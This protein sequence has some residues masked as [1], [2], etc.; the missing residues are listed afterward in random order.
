MGKGKK[1]KRPRPMTVVEA[2]EQLARAVR[3]EQGEATAPWV[4]LA[5][6]DT[7]DVA[8]ADQWAAFINRPGRFY[9]ATIDIPLDGQ[10]LGEKLSTTTTF[11]AD[12]QQLPYLVE[13][14]RQVRGAFGLHASISLA[15]AEPNVE[16]R[17]MAGPPARKPSTEEHRAAHREVV[18][19]H[20]A[21]R[22]LPSVNG[23]GRAHREARDRVMAAAQVAQRRGTSHPPAEAARPDLILRE[24]CCGTP[25]TAPHE[26]G[27]SYEPRPDNPIDYTGPAEVA[28]WRPGL[29]GEDGSPWE[30]VSD[31]EFTRD[32]LAAMLPGQTRAEVAAE[33][34][35]DPEQIG[36]TVH[37]AD[38][39]P[40]DLAAEL[41]VPVESLRRIPMRG[42]GYAYTVTPPAEEPRGRHA[43]PDE[44]GPR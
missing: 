31:R 43:A 3:R 8:H 17:R 40:E 16:E 32:E 19:Q 36:G 6:L 41:G 9:V 37:N 1:N 38:M 33:L 2:Q 12:D 23:I 4:D 35:Q 44:A 14:L 21:E 11:K 34:G 10:A 39:L 7:P 28:H 13:V 30:P 15:P 26:P 22:G 42:G 5:N 24:W 29:G 25:I 20:K 27:C 18:R